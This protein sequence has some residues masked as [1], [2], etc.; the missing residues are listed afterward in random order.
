MPCVL[1][2]GSAPFAGKG[3]L[4]LCPL[5]IKHLLTEEARTSDRLQQLCKET[6]SAVIEISGE[7]GAL[8][9]H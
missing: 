9:H 3:E 2:D 6:S 4:R 8:T 5:R 1:V 7:G